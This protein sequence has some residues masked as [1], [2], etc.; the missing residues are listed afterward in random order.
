MLSSLTKEQLLSLKSHRTTLLEEGWAGQGL[1]NDFLFSFQPCMDFTTFFAFAAGGSL[2][3]KGKIIPKWS[4]GNCVAPE[5]Q[6]LKLNIFVYRACRTVK[7][8]D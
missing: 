2:P 3:C 8:A 4:S 6:P 1:G 7:P 5:S